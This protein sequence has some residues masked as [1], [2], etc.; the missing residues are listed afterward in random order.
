MQEAKGFDAAGGTLLFA[1]EARI[2]MRGFLAVAPRTG[3][4]VAIFVR[5]PLI[6]LAFEADG[7]NFHHALA[8]LRSHYLVQQS[9]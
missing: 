8:M 6:P 7:N 9:R 4:N 2:G 1:L 3:Q 5:D